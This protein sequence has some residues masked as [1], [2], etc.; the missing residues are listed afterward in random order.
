[1]TQVKPA[2]YG[3]RSC[4]MNELPLELIIHIFI[5]LH[6]RDILSIRRTC[7]TLFEASTS[8]IIW[9]HFFLLHEQSMSGMPRLD[10][11]IELYESR[12]LERLFLRSESLDLVCRAT[13]KKLPR[14]FNIPTK[15][16]ECVHL[17][18]GGRWLLVVTRTGSVEYYDLD[19]ESITGAPLI[20]NQIGGHPESEIRMSID[21]DE[22]APTLSFNLALSLIPPRP[23]S[24]LA[25]SSDPD[26]FDSQKIQVWRISLVIQD[27]T[28]RSIGLSASRLASF[29]L[30]LEV[31]S[32][33]TLSLLGTHVAFYSDCSVTKWTGCSY[34]IIVEWTR[35]KDDSLEYPR[36]I[37]YPKSVSKYCKESMHL[38]PGCRLIIFDRHGTLS[39]HRYDS[40]PEIRSMPTDEDV[41]ELPHEMWCQPITSTRGWIDAPHDRPFS[42]PHVFGGSRRFLLMDPITIRGIII[43][44][45]NN[46]L[47]PV[48]PVRIVKFASELDTS[49]KTSRFFRWQAIMECAWLHIMTHSV[50][51]RFRG[52][53][54]QRFMKNNLHGYPDWMH[55]SW[56]KNGPCIDE[57]SGRAVF[58]SKGNPGR[59]NILDFAFPP[60]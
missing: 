29:P 37:L 51:S 11:P 47:L 42:V 23:R 44:D 31:L 45:T 28:G 21:M 60:K 41:E 40:V 43:Q 38:L 15:Q 49:K 9:V 7:K 56:F 57:A 25:P 48:D 39:L 36:R 50:P 18:E 52:P 58:P 16:A 26:T 19:A 34:Y 5:L 14:K 32:V 24:R 6:W 22:N 55:S 53:E 3:Q 1:M 4:G 27:Q 17:V 30:D 46:T 10:R 8:K 12:E 2:K 59:Q 13:G 35:T 54:L 20:P 33:E